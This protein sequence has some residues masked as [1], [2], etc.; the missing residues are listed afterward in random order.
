MYNY[1]EPGMHSIVWLVNKSSK[2]IV[3]LEILIQFIQI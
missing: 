3:K 1:Q 2:R